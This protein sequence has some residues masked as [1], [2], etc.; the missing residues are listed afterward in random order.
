[1]N[2]SNRLLQ[3]YRQK[4]SLATNQATA[5]KLGVK[6][7][8]VSMW[9]N[10]KSHPNAEAIEAMC[11]ATG[12]K[13]EHWLPLIEADRSRTAGDR[14]AW[15]R[16]AQAAATIVGTLVLIRYGADAHSAAAFALS[17]V[18]IMRN[19]EGAR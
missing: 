14:R 13:L 1:M 16:L 3:I 4:L 15:L 19:L 10:E 12:E 6:Q 9:L 18:Y 17:P 2:N 11:K 5:S 7:P 8:T